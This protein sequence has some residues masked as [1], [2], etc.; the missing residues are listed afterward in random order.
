MSALLLP[1]LEYPFDGQASPLAEEVDR[2][3]YRWGEGWGI[4]CLGDPGEYRRTRV[5]WLAAYTAPSATWAGLRLLA[6]WQMW[7]F[8]FDDGYCDESEHGAQPE[9]MIRRVVDFLGALDHRGPALDDVRTVRSA[10]EA[11][12]HAALSDLA[13]RLRADAQGFQRARFLSAVSGYFMAQCWETANRSAA[14]RGGLPPSPA[15]YIRLR[16]DSGAVRTCIALTDVAGGYRLS[17]ED[18]DHPRVTALTDMAVDVACWANDILSYP[19]EVRRSRIVHSLP[20]VLGHWR[21]LTPQ[22]ALEAAARMHNQQVQR[23]LAAELPIRAHAAEP[24]RRYLDDL[25][26]WMTGNLRWSLSTGRYNT[27]EG[28][29]A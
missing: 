13:A 23:Y 7:L 27:G 2:A 5:G 19:K 22:A 25:R 29:T 24:L 21:Q 26:S 9:A 3:C 8:A 12:F 16:R 4:Y 20:A 18:Y 10:A 1:A 28:R 14:A 6:D 15:E 11:R 17:A